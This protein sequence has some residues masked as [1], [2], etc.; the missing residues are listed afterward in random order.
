[1]RRLAATAAAAPGD[2]PKAP[3][4]KRHNAALAAIARC[5][6]R[7]QGTASPDRLNT[8]TR[9]IHQPQRAWLDDR[10]RGR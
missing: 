2:R 6:P 7:H 5:L 9:P 3:P 10:V 8:L 1:M 4:M